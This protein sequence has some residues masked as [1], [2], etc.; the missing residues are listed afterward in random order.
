MEIEGAMPVN[1]VAQR[2][3][4][5]NSVRRLGHVVILEPADFFDAGESASEARSASFRCA[6]VREAV[7]TWREGGRLAGRSG[8]AG[9]VRARDG[10]HSAVSSGGAIHDVFV[11]LE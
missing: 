8:A 4:S 3:E 6:G 7:A 2:R 9:P 5:P 11:T 10:C 1:S